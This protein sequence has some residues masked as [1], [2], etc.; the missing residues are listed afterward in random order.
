M[1]CT[2][3]MAGIASGDDRSNDN[4]SVQPSGEESFIQFRLQSRGQVG[5]RSLWLW[6]QQRKGTHRTRDGRER[7]K[8]KGVETAAEKPKEVMQDSQSGR[9][10][11]EGGLTT[12]S[13]PYELA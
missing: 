11:Q 7:E 3:V 9:F 8:K 12:R 6:N 10:L 4:W 5:H 1:I 2:L 13:N